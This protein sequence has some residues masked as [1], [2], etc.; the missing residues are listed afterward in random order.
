MTKAYEK[1]AERY[2]KRARL[3]KF[4]PGQEV[5]RRNIVQ[6]NFAKNLNS[7]FCKKFLRCRVVRP[8]GNNM[9]ELE[10][11]DGKGIGVYHVK[12]IKV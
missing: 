6:S 7:K 11:M 12:D 9:C 10:T 2:N 3:V 1:S 8:V 5:Y 4:I